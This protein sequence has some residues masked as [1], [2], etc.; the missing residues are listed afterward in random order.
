MIKIE[1]GTSLCT[2]MF[3]CWLVV[4]GR[5]VGWSVMIFEK[6]EGKLNFKRSYPEEHAYNLPVMFY[7][8]IEDR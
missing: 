7:S 2:L 6:K 5:L 3:V 4:G 1:G 8:C